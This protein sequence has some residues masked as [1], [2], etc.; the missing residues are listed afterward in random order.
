VV[1]EI[2]RFHPG[3][4]RRETSEEE[5]VVAVEVIEEIEEVPGTRIE[6]RI[7]ETTVEVEVE[8]V[9]VDGIEETVMEDVVEVEAGVTIEVR[10]VLFL[11]TTAGTVRSPRIATMA[12]VEAVV[13]VAAVERTGEEEEAAAEEVSGTARTGPSL[14]QGMRG[15]RKNSSTKAMDL[16]A[17]TLTGTRIFLS[18]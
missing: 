2:A 9:E 3:L 10:E 17:S 6:E 7:G 13:A 12:E 15:L 18:R 4:V 8:E 11:P 1:E 5:V 16:L 14:S